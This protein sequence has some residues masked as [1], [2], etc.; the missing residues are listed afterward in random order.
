MCPN[1]WRI[2]YSSDDL[3]LS[4]RHEDTSRRVALG[5]D[6]TQI[7]IP[8]RSYAGGR[9]YRRV[10]EVITF[11]QELHPGV[12]PPIPVDVLGDRN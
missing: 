11:F 5:Y 10:R 4:Q 2:A 9:S 1:E 6:V 7:T 12:P 8:G 3:F